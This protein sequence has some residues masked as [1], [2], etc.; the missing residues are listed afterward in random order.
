MSSPIDSD[1]PSPALSISTTC[2]T[3]SR[4]TVPDDYDL[5]SSEESN[6]MQGII[7]TKIKDKIIHMQLTPKYKVYKKRLTRMENLCGQFKTFVHRD[8]MSSV[9]KRCKTCMGTQDDVYSIF[10]NGSMMERM[11]SKMYFKGCTNLKVA[12]MMSREL[13][14]DTPPVQVHM[15]VLSACMGILV[16]IR[17]SGLMM[18]ILANMG[19]SPYYIIDS[20]NAVRFKVNTSEW[21]DVIM[22]K[23]N[24]WTITT[25]GS[26]IIRMTW[27]ALEWTQKIEDDIVRSCD[28]QINLLREFFEESS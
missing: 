2:S 7:K 15:I 24:D 5:S 4:Y 13:G 6:S 28:I 25:R 12:H 16:D 23:S 20:T 19:L 9:T 3:S 11:N 21:P 27:S 14:M 17:P 8:A 22:P 10:G 18:S 26:V 1:C